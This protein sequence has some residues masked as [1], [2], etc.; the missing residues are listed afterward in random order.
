MKILLIA[1]GRSPITKH[2]IESLK[3]LGTEVVL[4]S[5]YPCSRPDNVDD[6]YCIPAAFAQY[7]GNQS[8]SSG[9]NTSDAS[10]MRSQIVK[11][12]RPLLMKIRYILGPLTLPFS[13][14]ELNRIIHRTKPDIVHALR[15]PFEGMLAADIPNHIPFAVTIWGNDLTL[16]A[17]GSWLM[18]HMTIKTLERADGLAADTRRDIRLGK[19]WGFNPNGKTLVVPGSGGIPFTELRITALQNQDQLVW[20]PL[21]KNVVVNPRGFRPG[22]VRNDT[23][24]QS[25][26][27]ILQEC[28]NTV[29]VCFAMADQ[30][31][32]LSWVEK[33][34]ISRNVILL[35]F[36]PQPVLWAI[37][38]KA[39]VSVSVS[40]HDGTPNSLLEAMT[41]GC[42]PVVGDIESMR[43]WIT[44]GING[45]LVDPSN[46]GQLAA[47]VITAL[48]NDQLRESAADI[49]Q[50]I[51]QERAEIS[52]VST[53][54]EIFYQQLI[55]K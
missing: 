30:P 7:G 43:E 23:F 18:K 31:E 50:K 39:R 22:S 32:A 10:E 8:G 47:A 33:L 40:E 41:C 28:P 9:G 52:V 27:L 13:R 42:F 11:D 54:I 44:P 15:I 38:E 37:Y 4:V 20:L 48:Q 55:S 19:M 29:F 26:P 17:H 21:D 36:Q 14:I 51:I 5:S 34:N 16:H 25:I 53:Q 12:F 3:R 35:P 2:W 1:D 24:F 6:F 46:P 49:N 45:L